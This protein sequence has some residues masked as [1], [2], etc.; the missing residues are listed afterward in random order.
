MT[1]ITLFVIFLALLS[2]LVYIMYGQGRNALKECFLNMIVQDD[3][4]V[5]SI[6]IPQNDFDR[7]IHILAAKLHG[8]LKLTENA[9][10]ASLLYQDSISLMNN[11]QHY[12]VASTTENKIVCFVKR[13]DITEPIKNFKELSNHKVGVVREEDTI[14]VKALTKAYGM[15]S[16]PQVVV[17]GSLKG[18]KKQLF[19]TKS[20][21]ALCIVANPKNPALIDISSNKVS[22]V[23]YE[24]VDPVKLHYILPCT[25]QQDMDLKLIFPKYVDRYTVKKTLLIDN[26]IVSKNKN[27]GSYI[28]D[29]IVKYYA[30]RFANI[31]Y[32]GMHFNIHPRTRILLNNEDT[33]YAE[34]ENM[35]IEGFEGENDERK[36][37][38]LK[39]QHNIIGY[40]DYSKKQFEYGGVV[41]DGVVLKVG[42]NVTLASQLRNDE[43]GIYT[44]VS[45]NDDAQKTLLQKTSKDAYEQYA[46]Q[47]GTANELIDPMYVC[48]TNPSIKIRGLC[49]SDYDLNGKKK[50]SRDIW[51]KPCKYDQE[52]PFFQ[53]N[54]SYPNYRGGCINGY[55]E[56]PIGI[57][58][59]GYR[60][61]GSESKPFC[62]NCPDS[63]EPDCCSKLANPVY[64]FKYDDFQNPEMQKTRSTRS[65]RST[66]EHFVGEMQCEPPMQTH[67]YLEDISVKELHTTLMTRK[68][69]V[70]TPQQTPFNVEN[71]LQQV[72]GPSLED[73]NVYKAKVVSKCVDTLY[74]KYT[75]TCVLYKQ[76]KAYGK[77]IKAILQERIADGQILVLDVFVTGSIPQAEVHNSIEHDSPLIVDNQHVSNFMC[78]RA[79]SLKEDR[80]LEINMQDQGFTCKP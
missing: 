43:N 49:L 33:T 9:S 17:V 46:L 3:N 77:I 70:F 58:R 40:Y 63:L 11:P 28:Q 20:I 15:T 24:D 51:D 6:F 8:K 30:S 31:N 41:L 80:N 59:V 1:N 66:Q 76:D 45:V 2:V 50:S 16:A 61:I 10:Q 56:M 60:G 18:G 12:I 67:S 13:S 65:T 37:I 47:A 25:S 78:S 22:M 48:F 55:C 44:V 26:L 14:I 71:L 4:L 34:K 68:G 72:I 39:P 52:C 21:D 69:S 75:V 54:K 35:R 38:K 29:L 5:E 42:D 79:R 62:S 73:Y 53:A 23:D 32:L 57:E 27:D 64:A 19:D 7:S 36:I 74:I